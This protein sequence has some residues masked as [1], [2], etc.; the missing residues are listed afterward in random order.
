[1]QAPVN[2]VSLYYNYK[3]HSIV[4]LAVCDAQYRYTCMYVHECMYVCM[5]VCMCII[6]II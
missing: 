5:Y 1:M 6:S 3:T 4:L 2:S